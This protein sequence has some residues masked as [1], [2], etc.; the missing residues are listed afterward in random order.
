MFK[1]KK[2]LILQ[3]IKND[4]KLIETSVAEDGSKRWL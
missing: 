2:E 1:K 4:L 3:K